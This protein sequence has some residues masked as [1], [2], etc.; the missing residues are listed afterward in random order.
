MP[1]FLTDQ[2]IESLLAIEKPIRRR[3][4]RNLKSPKK[5]FRGQLVA[6]LTLTCGSRRFRLTAQR[7]ARKDSKPRKFSIILSY[8]IRP[9]KWMNLVRC[10]G[11]HA[12]HTNSLEQLTGT[13]VAVIAANTFHVHRATERYQAFDRDA[14]SY[15]IPTTAFD[16]FE[17]AVEFLCN[18]F[19]FF[20][21]DDPYRK[22]HPL[23]AD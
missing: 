23:F 2:Q 16:S 19:G 5:L 11:H 22:L 7:H 21:P 10:N 4:I 14:E 17:G 6:R 18:C 15:A 13:G 3:Q 20:V 1:V 8:E 12:Q 9:K